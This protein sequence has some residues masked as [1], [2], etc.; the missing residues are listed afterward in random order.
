MSVDQEKFFQVFEARYGKI[1]GHD[2]LQMTKRS[3]D[4]FEAVR[5]ENKAH[6][7]R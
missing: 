4:T 3:F 5:Q 7:W 6:T 2:G 1:T